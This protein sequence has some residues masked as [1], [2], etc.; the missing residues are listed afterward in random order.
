MLYIFCVSQALLKLSPSEMRRMKSSRTTQFI[1]W[2]VIAT[3]LLPLTKLHANSLV[4][5][6]SQEAVSFVH[7]FRV[8]RALPALQDTKLFK[9]F[10]PSQ[11]GRLTALAEMENLSDALLLWQES[12]TQEFFTTEQQLALFKKFHKPYFRT[13][14]FQSHLRTALIELSREDLI[15]LEGKVAEISPLRSRSLEAVRNFLRAPNPR[16]QGEVLEV[17]SQAEHTRVMSF[18]DQQLS[19][20]WTLTKRITFQRYCEP[21]YAISKAARESNSPDIVE[22]HVLFWLSQI[23]NELVEREVLLR[24]P[25]NRLGKNP[26]SPFFKQGQNLSDLRL[27]LDFFTN[28]M[29]VH[30]FHPDSEAGKLL[31]ELSALFPHNQMGTFS[32]FP[33]WGNLHQ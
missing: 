26:D 12:V 16:T 10:S 17:L 28:K 5:R 13:P 30:Y 1:V 29:S 19:S 18:L 8:S 11:I 2:A 27:V 24:T 15:H 32:N 9:S 33:N 23:A 3:T 22:S 25:S 4:V 6:V 21:F 7:G 31:Q 14:E 20:A